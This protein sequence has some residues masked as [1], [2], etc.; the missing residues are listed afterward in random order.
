VRLTYRIR[1][2]RKLLRDMLSRDML[3]RVPPR[4][5]APPTR[6]TSPDNSDSDNS[7]AS[8]LQEDDAG[9]VQD[10]KKSDTLRHVFSK[11]S[12]KGGG[13]GGKGGKGGG[14][15]GI[16]VE[17]YTSN[18]AT[19]TPTGGDSPYKRPSSRT[20]SSVYANV[21]NSLPPVVHLNGAP[22]L[23]CKVDLSKL[24]HMSQLSRGQELRQRTEL[25]DTRPSSKQR[26]SSRLAVQAPRPPTPEEGEI[27]DTPPSQQVASDQLK[28]HR[29]GLLPGGHTNRSSRSVMKTESIASDSKSSSS[30]LSDSGTIR[31]AP[32]RKRNASGSSVS[33]LSPVQC[34]VDAKA[35]N[36]SDHKDKNNKRQRRH[37]TNDDLSSIRSMSS[38]VWILT[39]KILK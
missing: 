33:S 6:T 30:M 13:K 14:K 38:Q 9:N 26:P 18:S 5:R 4:P 22:S 25:P 8:K 12:A 29:D 17:E 35:K 3:D 28:I 39:E 16:Y 36:S 21:V 2:Q 34:P 1:I 10:K 15:C 7:P 31:R 27:I 32:K 20:S 19:H 24:P 23:L 37:T 11:S